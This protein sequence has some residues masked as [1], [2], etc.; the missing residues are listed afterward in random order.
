MGS[1]CLWKAV[2]PDGLDVQM[3]CTEWLLLLSRQHASFTPQLRTYLQSP[4]LGSWLPV[5][6]MT[7]SPG[8]V[9]SPPRLHSA[10]SE[11]LK[12]RGEPLGCGRQCSRCN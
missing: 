5:L 10:G 1:L 3:K 8:T 7:Q 6:R 2:P 11:L 12:K 9:H 4:H